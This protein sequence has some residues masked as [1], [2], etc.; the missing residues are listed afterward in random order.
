MIPRSTRFVLTALTC[1]ALVWPAGAGDRNEQTRW[2]RVSSDHFSVLT[3]AGEKKGR[4]VAVRFEQMHA[5]LRQLLQKNQLKI[6]K[7]LEIVAFKTDAEY[8]AQ[9][10]LVEG[11]A[12]TDAAFFVPGEDRC[13]IVLNLF[14]PE[15]WR[16]VAH[17]FAHFFLDYNFYPSQSWFD[18]GFAEYFSTVSISDRDGAMG[19]DPELKMEWRQDIFGNQSQR[20]NPPRSLTQMLEEPVW[21]SIPD[22]FTL[23]HSISGYRE[24]THHVLYY[25][26]SWMVVHFLLN[27][28]KMLETA[29]YMDL[30]VN[31]K[32][33][34]SDAIQQAYGMSTDQ[35]DR[36]VK[37]YFESLLPLFLA[38]DASKREETLTTGMPPGQTNSFVAPLKAEDVATSA[39]TLPTAAA[40][41]MV[42]E[43]VLRLP[44]HRPATLSRLQELVSDPRRKTAIAYR[45]LAWAAIKRSNLDQAAKDL[46]HALESDPDDPWVHYELA[47]L[48]DL[49]GHLDAN[50]EQDLKLV[51]AWDPD[52]AQAHYLLSKVKRSA[53]QTEAAL[54][55]IR[56]AISLSPRDERYQLEM[57]Y[58]YLSENQAELAAA[59]L[60]RLRHS[61]NPQIAEAARTTLNNLQSAGK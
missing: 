36:A 1:I 20:I 16:A 51:L 38:L 25:A 12:T 14:E 37:D 56:A 46:K 39:R 40:Q 35:F 57:A 50:A 8:A 29:K 31:K 4:E 61:D 60:E 24:G 7:P 5:L 3:D 44:P 13:Y 26:E 48:N 21:L 58:V 55:E 2:V 28:N 43:M 59:A 15:N 33:A 49:M 42:A 34:T 27:T 30:A 17:Q 52:C 22:L 10:P 19:A 53:G 23:K 47:S 32:V 6:A 45:A 41:A 11:Q 54:D 18:E 9:A